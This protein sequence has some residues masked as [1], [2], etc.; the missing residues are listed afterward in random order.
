MTGENGDLRPPV[1]WD[2]YWL[3]AQAL[4]IDANYQAV[5]NRLSSAG[6]PKP[7]IET[8]STVRRTGNGFEPGGRL[9]RGT[10]DHSGVRYKNTHRRK[11]LKHKDNQVY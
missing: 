6:S 3:I 5:V 7:P 2:Q 10:G 9:I 8:T 4:Q 11:V 1:G